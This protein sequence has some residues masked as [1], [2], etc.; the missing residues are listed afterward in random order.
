[1]YKNQARRNRGRGGRL[2]GTAAPP[3]QILIKV[4]LVPID[5]NSKKIKGAKKYK[6]YK[7]PG[8]L[9]V[10]LLFFTYCNSRHA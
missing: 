6:P 10:T 8:K 7:I 5:N 4:D 9:P 2:G 3:S 1:M